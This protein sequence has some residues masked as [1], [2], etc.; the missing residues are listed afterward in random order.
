[1]ALTRWPAAPDPRLLPWAIWR[2]RNKAGPTPWPT[3]PA[4]PKYAWEFL[5]W[6]AWRRKGGEPST[7][8]DIIPKIPQWAWPLLKQLNIAVPLTPPP[9][10]P[11]PPNPTPPTSWHL[12]NPLVFTSWGWLTDSDFRNVE[13]IGQRMAEA[14]VGTVAL[15]G[16]MFTGDQ[17][18]RLRAFGFDIAVWGHADSRDA[19]YLALAEADGY[20]PQ[21][22][23][24]YQFDSAYANLKAGIGA[25][26]SRSIVT[27]LAGLETFA[28]R[29]D[30][31]ADGEPTTVEV[32]ELVA[33]GVTH[34]WVECYTGDMRPLD[35]GEFMFAAD[36]RGIYHAN[37]L[38]GLAR[39]DVYISTYQPD[40]NAYGRQMGV[41]LAEPM[42]PIDWA[43]LKNL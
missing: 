9:P 30:G 5:Q 4:I 21:I 14:G 15:Q 18:R 35:V 11:P 12:R 16:G 8:P 2:F 23:G 32:E 25:G 7:R 20:I 31:T 34:A 42:R 38:I 37:P 3:P 17:A 1:M 27:T 19:E 41:Y 36:R 26:L 33:I 24:I 43:A 13:V 10:P 6:A 40:L 39:P 22:E 29:P 28:T